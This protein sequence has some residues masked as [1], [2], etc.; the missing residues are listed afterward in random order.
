MIQPCKKERGLTRSMEAHKVLKEAGFDVHSYGTGSNVRLPGPSI[1]A[2]NVYEFG[3]PYDQIYK[4]LESQDARLYKH[5]GVLR[6]LDR[7]RKVKTAPEK[8]QNN[9]LVFDVI[10][11]CEVRCFD[12]VMLDLASRKTS[13]N[14][15][16]HV[17]NVDI[18]DDPENAAIGGQ[19]ILKLAQALAAKKKELDKLGRDLEDEIMDILTQWQL[20]HPKLLLLYNVAFY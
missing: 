16:V 1:E 4:E 3:T 5:N 17:I 2:P 12:S 6:M 8:F 19:G 11:C 14:R 9:F 13:L 18:K 15:P 20:E 10:F 7:N